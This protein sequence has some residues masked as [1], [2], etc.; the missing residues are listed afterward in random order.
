MRIQVRSGQLGQL[1]GGVTVYAALEGEQ[2]P[3][4]LLPSS[5]VRERALIQLIRGSGFRGAANET[6]L[7][8]KGN[9]WVLVVGIGKAKDLSLERVRQFAATA[10]R[11]V[12]ARSFTQLTLPVLRERNLGQAEIV[13]QAITEGALLGLYRY[14]KL[15]RV[16][17]H[18]QRKRIEAIT[19]VVE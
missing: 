16:P 9:G 17:K 1:R 11:T 12:R 13:A 18:E 14:D 7:L 15:K 10:A 4:R 5:S 2:H 3:E 19:L 8:P 6:T